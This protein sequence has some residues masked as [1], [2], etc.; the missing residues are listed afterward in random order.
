MNIF[1]L[2]EETWDR[3]LKDIESVVSL[4]PFNANEKQDVIHDAILHVINRLNTSYYEE[5]KLDVWVKKVAS[6][7]CKDR[8]ADPR[9]K[10]TSYYEELSKEPT[11]PYKYYSDDIKDKIALEIMIE[12][13]EELECLEKQIIIGRIN[14][15]S[16]FALATKFNKNK[17]TIIKYCHKALTELKTIIKYCHK[18]LTELREIINKKYSERYGEKYMDNKDE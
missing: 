4:F 17:K 15:E 9:K 11:F 5:G 1:N 6:N 16:Y 7:F 3:I 13:I 8:L 12:S 10:N 2:D 14:K 18:A